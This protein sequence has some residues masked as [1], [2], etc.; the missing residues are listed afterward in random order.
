M[1]LYDICLGYVS[2]NYT[3]L[4]TKCL[5]S[6]IIE[7]VKMR[8]LDEYYR[9]SPPWNGKMETIALADEL[10]NLIRNNVITSLVGIN[11][12]DPWDEEEAGAAWVE[13]ELSVLD[14]WMEIRGNYDECKTVNDFKDC[15]KKRGIDYIKVAID[16]CK[17]GGTGNN[18]YYELIHTRNS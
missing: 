12:C 14:Q 5:P 6:E 10:I 11:F 15:V 2:E 8:R 1:S 17:E 13:N 9:V 4:S 3:R 18:R 16:Y 7:D